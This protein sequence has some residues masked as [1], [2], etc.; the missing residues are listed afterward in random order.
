MGAQ[1]GTIR[2]STLLKWALGIVKYYT[3]GEK[4]FKLSHVSFCTWEQIDSRL[5][6]D[7]L[8]KLTQNIRQSITRKYLTIAGVLYVKEPNII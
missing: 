8:I 5:S 2:S 4:G 3:G 1:I 6:C 7:Y